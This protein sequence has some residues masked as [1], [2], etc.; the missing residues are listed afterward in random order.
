MVYLGTSMYIRG[1]HTYLLCT[2]CIKEVDVK[3]HVRCCYLLLLQ[4][5][6]EFN[7]QHRCSGCL[8][9][10]FSVIPSDTFHT[11]CT[12]WLCHHSEDNVLKKIFELILLL[13]LL[14][15]LLYY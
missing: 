9:K 13:L 15:L 10:A 5:P 4:S 12:D 2:K 8:I 7:Q 1:D 11:L 3:W 14:L 6:A